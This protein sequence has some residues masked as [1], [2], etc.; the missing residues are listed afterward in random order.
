MAA[1]AQV[2]KQE[3]LVVDD[4]PV[5]ASL[6]KHTL[7]RVAT[8]SVSEDIHGAIAHI[9]AGRPVDL[10]LCDLGLRGGSGAQLHAWLAEHRPD[11]LARIAFVTGG[12][13]TGAT[14]SFLDDVQPPCLYKPFTRAELL[15]F[16][17]NMFGPTR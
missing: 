5:I 10:I 7:S 17:G 8:V 6:M 13:C 16:T 2:D 9:E 14:Q 11:L 4:E 3:V 1:A 15:A 12:A